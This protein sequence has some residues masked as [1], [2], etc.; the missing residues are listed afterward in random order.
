MISG[1]RSGYLLQMQPIWRL[2][3]FILTAVFNLITHSHPS[4]VASMLTVA[5]RT[6]KVPLCEHEKKTC[7]REMSSTAQTFTLIIDLKLP[8]TADFSECDGSGFNLLNCKT[9]GAF[10]II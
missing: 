1:S 8:F 2:S 7:C 6:N 10:R 9:V 5:T 3:G 4:P